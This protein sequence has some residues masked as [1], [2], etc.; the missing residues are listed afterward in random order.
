MLALL[1]AIEKIKGDLQFPEGIYG[2]S[3]GS[4]VATAV[5]LWITI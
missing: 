4:I 5:A 2:C 1:A 3:I